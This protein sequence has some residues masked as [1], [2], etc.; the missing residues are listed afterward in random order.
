MERQSPSDAADIVH[1]LRTALSP[2]LNYGPSLIPLDIL[3]AVTRANNAKRPMTVKKLCEILPYS[4]TGIRYNIA[5]LIENEWLRKTRY[6][7]DRRVV[8]LLPTEQGKRALS[9][10]CDRLSDYRIWR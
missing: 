1:E 5:Q 8:H 4:V 2:A 9:Q 7:E 10:V 6:Q 3:V